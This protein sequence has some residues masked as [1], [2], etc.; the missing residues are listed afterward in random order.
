MR[1]HP[2]IQ[3]QG[4]SGAQGMN[5]NQHGISLGSLTNPTPSPLLLA[6]FLAENGQQLLLSLYSLLSGEASEAGIS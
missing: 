3:G 6:T 4:R 2:G 5:W 1:T